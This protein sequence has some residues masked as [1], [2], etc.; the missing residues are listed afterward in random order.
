MAC[1]EHIGL[2]FACEK[3]RNA[4]DFEEAVAC[5]DWI[6]ETY[7]AQTYANYLAGLE[8]QERYVREVLEQVDQSVHMQHA[9][10]SVQN[11]AS[12]HLGDLDVAHWLRESNMSNIISASE[13]Q[14]MRQR[15]VS[16]FD[17]AS[18]AS[19]VGQKRSLDL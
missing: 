9:Q 15:L 16:S 7:D 19:S 18:S 1:D 3:A 11:D 5:D 14:S 17:F 8:F 13:Y 12:S 6:Q 2:L 10:T 4:A